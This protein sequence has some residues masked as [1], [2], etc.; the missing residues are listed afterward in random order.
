[1]E[2]NEKLR[3]EIFK[4]IENQMRI[5]NP[6]ETK[7]TYN[8]LLKLGYNKFQVKQLIGQCVAVEIFDVL[9]HQQQFNETRYI[10]N[11]KKLPK[12]PFD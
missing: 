12:E 5:N 4:I 7:M 11:L 1:M 10:N 3:D 2:V 6:P 9:K 8:R